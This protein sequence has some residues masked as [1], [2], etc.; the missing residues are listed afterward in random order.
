MQ[1]HT[2]QKTL[3]GN[4]ISSGPVNLAQDGSFAFD[5][6]GLADGDNTV[7]ISV[8]DAAGNNAEA[9]YVVS[10]EEEIIVDPDPEDPGVRCFSR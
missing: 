4:I 3:D 9:S 2:K 6:S 5:V 8:N 1:R 7:K 10:Y